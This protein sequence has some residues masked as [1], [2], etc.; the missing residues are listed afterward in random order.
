MFSVPNDI[1]GR[2]NRPRVTYFLLLEQK[3][4]LPVGHREQRRTIE[5]HRAVVV[6]EMGAQ[7]IKHGKPR[8]HLGRVKHVV[9][10]PIGVL[11][12]QGRS[13]VHNQWL[14]GRA[15]WGRVVGCPEYPVSQR[16]FPLRWIARRDRERQ[17]CRFAWCD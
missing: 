10:L 14:V 2:F 4:R 6:G 13:G 12:D 17:G 7:T 9:G 1:G 11:F 15:C 8:G 5:S 3:W 16:L